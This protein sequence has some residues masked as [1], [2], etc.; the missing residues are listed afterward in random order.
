MNFLFWVTC[1]VHR[2]EVVGKEDGDVAKDNMDLWFEWREENN[3]ERFSFE[4][5]DRF[6][7]DSLVSWNSEPE[8]ICANWR[9]WKLSSQTQNGANFVSDKDERVD[10]LIEL[11]SKTVAKTIPF[12]AVEHSY[13]Q[14]P[15]QIQLRIAFWSFPLV[16]DD[17][18]LYSCLA[19]GSPEEFQR[20][21]LL[22]RAKAV[23]DALQIGKRIYNYTNYYH[24][25]R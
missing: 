25:C 9:G 7:E 23:R 13:P 22:V 5:S 6:E 19:N 21:E 24:K 15:E 1:V 18:R 8:S 3:D 16:E 11:C 17:L 12:E 10:S 14:I 2:N 20:G 4:D